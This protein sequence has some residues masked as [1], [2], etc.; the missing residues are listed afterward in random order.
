MMHIDLRGLLEFAHERHTLTG[1]SHH[2]KGTGSAVAKCVFA[3]L[4][5]VKFVVRMFDHRHTQT[6]LFEHTDQLLDQRGLA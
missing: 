6:P 1:R 5:N 2:F 4:V 3:G